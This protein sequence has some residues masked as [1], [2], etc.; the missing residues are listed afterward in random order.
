MLP[1]IPALADYDIDPQRGFLPP[2]LPLTSLPD[3]YYSKWEVVIDKV[4]ALILSR[5]IRST[6]DRLPVLSTAY[7]HSDAE[8]RRAY[9]VLTF[10]LHAY[11]WGGDIPEEVRERHFTM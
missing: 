9:V 5:R 3:P 8:W 2:E 11:I 6:V 7:L 4:H 1:P 10:M